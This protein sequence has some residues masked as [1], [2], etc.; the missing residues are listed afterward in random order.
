MIFIIGRIVDDYFLISSKI[1]WKKYFQPELDKIIAKHGDIPWGKT[2]DILRKK[3]KSKKIEN[4]DFFKPS[5][6][7][8][9]YRKI[10]TMLNGIKNNNT[11]NSSISRS[12]KN[13]KDKGYIKIN[14]I[15][16]QN[17]IKLTRKG[18][19]LYCS[20]GKEIYP[21]FDIYRDIQN[22]VRENIEGED[23]YFP[24]KIFYQRRTANINVKTFPDGKIVLSEEDGKT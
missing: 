2:S 20:I 22:E 16:G 11:A 21:Y 23:Y 1:R 24:R 18:Y 12:L 9:T 4:L 8:I 14:K 5:L 19:N 15:G 3:M 6:D 7:G 17:L 10:L 13:L